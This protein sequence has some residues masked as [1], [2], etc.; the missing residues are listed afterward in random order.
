MS[1][2]GIDLSTTYMGIPLK[3]PL[4]PSAGPLSREVD[5]VRALEDS[6]AAAVVMY[7]LFEEQI[8]HEK[9]EL[10]HYLEHGTESYAEALSYFP[11]TEVHHLGPDEYLEHLR[12]LKEAVDIPIIGSL[13]GITTGGW[14]DYAAGMEQAGADA[15]ELNVYYIPTDP[16]MDGR[17]VEDRY[18]NVLQAV[19][20]K[21]RIPI[22][23]K[24]S[25]YFS[26]PAAMARRLDDAGANALV[27]F[28][29][30]YQPD[31]DLESLEVFPNLL[32]S[33]PR[34]LRL[35]LRFIA[36][37]HDQM[38]AS[39]ALSSG[40]DS[41]Q[42]VLKGLMVGADVVMVCS[43]LLRHGPGR[44]KELRAG[45]RQWM[46]QHEYASVEQLK[47]SMSHRSSSDPSAFERANYMKALNNYDA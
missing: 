13:N 10:I 9:Q 12:R 43:T 26:S 20:S 32:L 17:A 28:N 42:D 35:P 31:I 3:N 27:L 30:F 15:L 25:P 40:V 7:S 23:M 29:R 47:G 37:L 38:H 11:D 33:S 14:I 19:K 45:V 18:V 24:L 2:D 6:G 44:V 41:P 46:E 16:A 5:T 34:E 39:L 36:I 22:S 8:E 21:V 4:V 1:R